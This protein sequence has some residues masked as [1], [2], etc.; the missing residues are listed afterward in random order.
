MSQT[1]DRTGED[2]DKARRPWSCGSAGAGGP[3]SPACGS[4]VEGGV[5][6]AGRSDVDDVVEGVKG[7][8]AEQLQAVWSTGRRS[9][10]P[11]GVLIAED[12]IDAATAVERLRTAARS[13]RQPVTD[14]VRD[15][16][17]GRPCVS[18]FDGWAAN[19]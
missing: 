8:Q 10:R 4:S 13:S 18:Y 3:G 9:S 11:K 7:R 14:L 19:T 15:L 17:T 12:G 6:E 1:V 2:I 5:G 16:I